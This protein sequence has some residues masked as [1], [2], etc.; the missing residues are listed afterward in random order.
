MRHRLK[1]KKLNRS[2]KHRR[3]LFKN[4]ISAL[5]EHGEIKT[6]LAKAK[7]VKGLVDKLITTAK[8]GTL[9]HRRQLASFFG[10]R[11][12]ANKLV[13]DI[14]PKLK[15]RTSGYTRIV[16]LGRRTGDNAMMAK[17]EL[18]S[19]AKTKPVGSKKTKHRRQT[20]RSEKKP[21]PSLS[22]P[23]DISAPQ[24][25]SQVAAPSTASTQ[26]RGEK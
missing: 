16:R 11:Q 22:T 20:D 1:G 10:K 2:T 23:K 19:Q 3:A 25:Q 18:V 9:H 24:A 21:S 15:S 8:K 4:L 5:V 14:A 6:T 17:L 7:A 26:K 12:P 13:E